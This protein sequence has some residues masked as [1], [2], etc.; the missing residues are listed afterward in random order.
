[1]A[2]AHT[3]DVRWMARALELAA[4]GVARTHPNPMVGAVVVRGGR[5]VG[6]G[7]HLYDRR[8]H[9]EVLALQQ[10]GPR[11]RGA[12]LYVNLEP[13][14]HTGR[15][16]PCVDAIIAAGIRRVVA[17]MPDPNP[18]V[19]GRGFRRLRKAGIAVTVGI[20]RP[21]A[22]QLNDAF[23]VW[24]RAGRPRVLLKAALT[25]DGQLALPPGHPRRITGPEAH[26][27][28]QELRHAAD[29]ILTGIG[30]VLADDPLLT[31]RSGLPRRRRLLRVILDSR[32]RLPLQ[33]RLVRSAAGDLVVFTT[34]AASAA[35]ERQLR[36]AGVEVVRV[37]ARMGRPDLGAVLAELG[38]REILSLLVEGGA[39]VNGS[40][41]AAGLVDRVVLFYAP[42]LAGRVTV[43]LATLQ[44]HWKKL[45]K[46]LVPRLCQYGEDF[47]V[48][49]YL[50]NV[51]RDH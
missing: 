14:S 27:R 13:C 5:V 47:A 39:R 35:R 22:E 46:L 18:A 41:L 43:P 2:E 12:T 37:P 29:A 33:S 25:L 15:T 17:A 49:G 36:Q 51:Y 9:A 26:R 8:H 10:A 24:I 28:V 23:A 48:E 6:E 7:F 30:T 1:M 3:D 32:L 20:G 21:Q 44:Q 42:R 50:R 31:D 38:R 34:E 19:H 40:L 45:P 16:P 11:A 4:R